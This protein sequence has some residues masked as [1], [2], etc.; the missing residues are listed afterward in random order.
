MTVLRRIWHF[1]IDL[2][3]GILGGLLYGHEGG[4][5]WTSTN[6]EAQS[7]PARLGRDRL[8]KVHVHMRARPESAQAR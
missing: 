4:F 2:L 8:R 5:L 7:E 6:T 1:V 3:D